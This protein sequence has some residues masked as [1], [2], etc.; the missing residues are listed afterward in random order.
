MALTKITSNVLADEFTASASV[1]SDNDVDFSSAA[2]FTK[3]ITANTTFDIEN[4][5]VG[6]VKNILVEGNGTEYTISFE[7][8]GSTGETFNQIGTDTYDTTD[9]NFT[10]IQVVCAD[11][12]ANSEKFWYTISKQ[13]SA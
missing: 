4:P 10:L 12:T 2:V 11:D 7:M 3:E 13:A 8:S 5:K 9:G 1:P 6:D